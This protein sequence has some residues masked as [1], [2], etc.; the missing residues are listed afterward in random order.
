LD[1]RNQDLQFS[2]PHEQQSTRISVLKATRLEY[3]KGYQAG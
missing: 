2:P 3:S 1:F